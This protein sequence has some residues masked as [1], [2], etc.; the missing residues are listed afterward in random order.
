MN[1][2]LR[3]N[4]HNKVKNRIKVH[5]S[6]REI[7]EQMID[8]NSEILK[9]HKEMR[10]IINP[11]MMKVSIKDLL[12]TIEATETIDQMKTFDKIEAID[13][14]TILDKI[15]AID[16]MR[17]SGKIETIDRMT[18]LGKTEIE[19]IKNQIHGT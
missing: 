13:R 9:G 11:G 18:I 14:M 15:R 19:N 6:L 16:Q 1:H 8:I 4:S 3:I 7:L 10:D 17:I 5:K 2:L 12:T